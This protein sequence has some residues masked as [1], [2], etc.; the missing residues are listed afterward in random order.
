[1]PS[2]P[3]IYSTGILLFFALG[4]IGLAQAAGDCAQIDPKSVASIL[5]VP[6]A[7]PNPPAH[8]K[9]PPEN[10]DLLS[11]GYAEATIDPSARTLSYLVY[12]PSL[13]NFASV[14]ASLS[15]GNFP[16]KQSFTP[17]VGKQSTGWF[18]AS[19]REDSFEGS[20][21]IQSGGTVV[22]IKIGGMPSADGVKNALIAAGKKFPP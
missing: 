6:A 3:S 16:R 21:T 1:M 4:S 9:L 7:R 8:S 22:V 13:K 20:I 18:R 2:Y 15:T 11:C 5:G 10:M 17:N 19:V 12:S 14:Y